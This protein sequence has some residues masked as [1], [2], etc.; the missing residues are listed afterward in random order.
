MKKKI[1]LAP[2]FSIENRIFSLKNLQIIIIRDVL[3]QGFV[4]KHFTFVQ[5]QHRL[6]SWK[7]VTQNQN[8][9]MMHYEIVRNGY[10]NKLL[11]DFL[12]IYGVWS[13][14]AN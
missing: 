6:L 4:T 2:W 7:P 14:K 12:S 9:T 1:H 3:M 8:I 10:E 11:Y 13:K 5:I